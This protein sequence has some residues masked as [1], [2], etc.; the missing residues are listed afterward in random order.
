MI[1]NSEDMQSAE[2]EIYSVVD[3]FRITAAYKTWLLDG[4][5]V[6][7]RQKRAESHELTQY[8]VCN[9]RMQQWWWQHVQRPLMEGY[10]TSPLMEYKPLKPAS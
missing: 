2:G 7:Q 8:Q 1:S 6:Q 5:D 3:L 9:G 4:D 10:I